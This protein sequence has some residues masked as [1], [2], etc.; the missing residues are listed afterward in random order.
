MKKRFYEE[1]GLYCCLAGEVVFLSFNEGQI[2]MLG[3][4]GY[5]IHSACCSRYAE[6]G[7]K[8]YGS[9]NECKSIF[10]QAERIIKNDRSL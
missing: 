8:H 5:A 2:T 4:K 7:C 1:I 6:Y 9:A 10:K 3:G